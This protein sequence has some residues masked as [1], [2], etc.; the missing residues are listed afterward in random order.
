MP[1]GIYFIYNSSGLPAR[2]NC[3]AG[4][5][6]FFPPF[7]VFG[8]PFVYLPMDGN[9]NDYY[10]DYSPSGGVGNINTFVTGRVGQAISFNAASYLTW[11]L[12]PSTFWQTAFTAVCAFACYLGGPS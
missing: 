8:D 12:L 4:S 2:V 3:A 7:S 11:S 10:G 5:S 1:N 9:Y 6:Y